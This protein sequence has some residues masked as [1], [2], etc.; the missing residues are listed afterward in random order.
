MTIRRIA[1]SL[2]LGGVFALGVLAMLGSNG[3][4]ETPKAAEVQIPSPGGI[5]EDVPA[6]AAGSF[7]VIPFTTSVPMVRVKFAA[8]AVSLM[9][10]AQD[11]SPGSPVVT[12]AEVATGPSMP[13]GYVVDS[14]DTTPSPPRWQITIKLPATF[15][16]SI[17]FSIS[18]ST[19]SGGTASPPLKLA[20]SKRSYQVG[21]SVPGGG[22]VTSNPKGIYC[23]PGAT[24]DCDHTFDPPPAGVVL[25]LELNAQ[26]YQSLAFSGWS[27]ACSAANSNSGQTGST[28]TLAVDGTRK[29]KATASFGGSVTQPAMCPSILYPHFIGTGNAPQCQ[30]P[31]GAKFGAT[32]DGQGFFTC[33]AGNGAPFCDTFNDLLKQPG[34][35]YAV[36]PS[37]PP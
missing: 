17:G 3:T 25:T 14:M 21:V 28:C 2:G 20:F 36:D 6:A 23:G 29:V 31:V 1:Q 27:D 12:I 30:P 15:S 24:A 19:V 7:T 33:P 35:C 8:P 37:S 11:D 34:G 13:T 10:T 26:S 4:P 18:I 5:W 16:A 22:H 9:V 32:C